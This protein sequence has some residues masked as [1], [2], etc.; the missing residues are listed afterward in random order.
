MAA[1]QIS[2]RRWCG[3]HAGCSPD[4]ERP[5]WRHI[6]AMELQGLAELNFSRALGGLPVS[7]MSGVVD[8][9]ARC[10]SGVTDAPD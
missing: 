9:P 10:M 1:R 5:E 2:R 7:A 6:D 4:V 8:D 3:M